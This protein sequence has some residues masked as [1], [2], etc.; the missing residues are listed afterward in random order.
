MYLAVHIFLQKERVFDEM[1]NVQD[2]SITK[3]QSDVGWNSIADYLKMCIT[4]WNILLQI[5]EENEEAICNTIC[6]G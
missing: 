5:R 4:Q 6:D 1:M 2:A 3:I